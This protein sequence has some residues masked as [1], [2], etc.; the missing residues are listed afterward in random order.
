MRLS[1]KG[2]ALTMAVLW[3]GCLLFV[4]LINLG[5][6]SYGTN[7]LAAVSSVY[8]GFHA[9]RTFGDILVGTGYAL[10][11]GGIAG[12]LFCWLYNWFAGNGGRR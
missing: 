3:G 4:G 1:A 11:D 6:P 9:T 12:L 5:S 8:P 2:L 10:V 7:F